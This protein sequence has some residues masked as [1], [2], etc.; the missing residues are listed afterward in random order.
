VV[1]KKT[2]VKRQAIVDMAAEVF[3]EK[4]FERASMAEIRQRV[5]GSNATLYN[6]FPSKEALFLEVMYQA[7][8]AEITAAH[9]MLDVE[10]DDI[11]EALQN[12]G[13]SLLALMYSLDVMA[14][15]RLATS[16]FGNEELSRTFYERGPKRTMDELSAFLRAAMDK[17]QL[18][19]CD[20]AVATLHLRALLESEL[21]DRFIFQI[22]IDC[23]PTRIAQFVER[24]VAVFM[25]A[26]GPESASRG[27]FP[28]DSNRKSFAGLGAKSIQEH[29]E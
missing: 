1:K 2:E 11:S 22:E 20:P 16:S 3:R 14:I 17:G 28:G 5:G 8:Q 7:N 10:A 26:Y 24:A 19:Q 4:G 12:F 6:Y 15:R 21:L 23:N 27:D 18:R 25:A 9:D 29:I 13:K